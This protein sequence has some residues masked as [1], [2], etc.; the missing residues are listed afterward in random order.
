MILIKTD[1]KWIFLIVAELDFIMTM[2]AESKIDLFQSFDPL[3]NIWLICQQIH[4]T[5]WH[6]G[7]RQ[8]MDWFVLRTLSIGEIFHKFFKRLGRNQINSLYFAI[9]FSLQFQP[10][11]NSDS[12]VNK[13]HHFDSVAE[14]L[15]AIIVHN[16]DEVNSI[17]DHS[18]GVKGHLKPLLALLSE[19]IHLFNVFLI[20]LK[21]QNMRKRS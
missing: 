6:F 12:I 1:L 4:I 7:N 3:S 5:W 10:F 21:S 9:S 18:D 14:D 20:F 16:K 13:L 11:H 15:K 8:D 19:R 2:K 17:T